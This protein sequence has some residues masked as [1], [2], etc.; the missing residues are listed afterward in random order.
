MRPRGLFFWLL[1]RI[2][3]PWVVFKTI[4][5]S[6]QSYHRLFISRLETDSFIFFDLRLIYCS[7]NVPIRSISM[8]F[9]FHGSHV[10]QICGIKSVEYT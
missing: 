1:N 8:T 4:L 7:W 5:A 2:C 6:F 10:L 3:K 9:F